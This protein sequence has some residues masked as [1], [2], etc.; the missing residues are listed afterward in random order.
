[1]LLSILLLTTSLSARGVGAFGGGCPYSAELAALYHVDLE[2]GRAQHYNYHHNDDH[3]VDAAGIVSA[4]TT[5]SR[6][7]GV[8]DDDVKDAVEQPLITTSYHREFDKKR[9]LLE[10]DPSST[11][12]SSSSSSPSSSLSSTSPSSCRM[13][14]GIAGGGHLARDAEGWSA[15]CPD[16]DSPYATPLRWSADVEQHMLRQPGVIRRG[17]VWYD[18]TKNR[19]RRGRRRPFIIPP[20]SLGVVCK[21]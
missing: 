11:S 7:A 8:A 19:K 6:D 1:M 13:Q 12:S 5:R 16:A 21:S 2:Q 18:V 3:T 14:A 4:S 10:E 17:K 9:N 20:T 15:A